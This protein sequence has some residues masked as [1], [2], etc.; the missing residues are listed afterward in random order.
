[1]KYRLFHSY[2]KQSKYIGVNELISEIPGQI[3][4]AAKAKKLTKKSIKIL[5]DMRNLGELM[6]RVNDDKINREIQGYFQ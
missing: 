1:M 2:F 3:K 5:T 4:K 6:K